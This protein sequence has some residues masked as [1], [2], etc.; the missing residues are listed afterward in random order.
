MAFFVRE[1]IA[2]N[3]A[4]REVNYTR[5]LYGEVLENTSDAIFITDVNGTIERVNKGFEVLTGYRGIEVAQKRIADFLRPDE[6][7]KSRA[8]E[9]PESTQPSRE[10]DA[11][12]IGRDGKNRQVL[13]RE[14]SLVRDGVFQGYQAVATDITARKETEEALRQ[15]N[16]FNQMLIGSLPFGISIV[17]QDG[18][19]LFMS[20][21]LKKLVGANQLGEI[22]WSIFRDNPTQCSECPL[23]DEASIGSIKTIE[24]SGVF[25]GRTFQINHSSLIYNGRNAILQV[26]EDVTETR[27]LQAQLSQAQKMEGLGIL[28]SGVA[29]DFNNILGIILGHA[30]F[31]AEKIGDSNGLS[32]SFQAIVKSAQRGASLVKQMLTFARKAQVSFSPISINE[33]VKDVEKILLETFPKTMS[34]D[35]KLSGK[36]PLIKGDATQIHQALLNLCVN[37][38]DAMAGNGEMTITTQLVSGESIKAR[39]PSAVFPQYVLLEVKDNGIGMNEETIK[40]IFEPFFTT[41]EI[42]KGTGLGLAVVFGIM[43]NHEGLIDVVSEETKGTTMRLFFPASASSAVVVEEPV[44]D[45]GANRGV[46]TIL[47]IEDE[48]ML[49]ELA[50][51][52][53]SMNGYKVFTSKDGN[54]GI[55]VFEKNRTDIA[56]VISDLGLPKIS[57]KDVLSEIRKLKPSIKFIIATGFLDPEEKNELF[58]RGVFDVISKPYTPT[59]LSEKVRKALDTK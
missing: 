17:D 25:N 54:E 57:G 28:A 42:G 16:S 22:C 18:K 53:L 29:H 7:Q 13:V 40:H 21:K 8:G 26:F 33:S 11:E 45:S 24:R 6:P 9:L 56:L 44:H 38:R 36:L 32:K 19:I 12:L 1:I 35:C 58:R 48:E 10:Y 34:I 14:V 59:S 51:E 2:R 50:Y 20:D 27:A 49:L 46:E 47:V 5:S 30:S 15:L 55:E 4:T 3:E 23:L 43:Q 37:A 31:V 39:F 41:K 52:V